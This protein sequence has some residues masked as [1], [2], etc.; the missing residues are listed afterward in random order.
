MSDDDESIEDFF[1]AM[2][3]PI[4]PLS[5]EDTFMVR[6]NSDGRLATFRYYLRHELFYWYDAEEGGWE[7]TLPKKNQDTGI[8]NRVKAT[9]HDWAVLRTKYY[10]QEKHL[11]YFQDGIAGIVKSDIDKVTQML[12]DH[13]HIKPIIECDKDSLPRN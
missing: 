3:M 8:I 13:E 12:L 7:M 11:P 5:P 1:D 4:R 10:L 6:M 2:G 9:K